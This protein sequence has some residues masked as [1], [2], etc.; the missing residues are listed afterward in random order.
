MTQKFEPFPPTGQN[1]KKT[2]NCFKAEKE[3][4]GKRKK[5]TYVEILVFVLNGYFGRK[6][7]GNFLKI[8]CEN[9]IQ[10]L[11]D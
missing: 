8:H 2:E 7:Y 6:Y 1:S 10:Y 4:H 9:K 11:A 5:G 3:K